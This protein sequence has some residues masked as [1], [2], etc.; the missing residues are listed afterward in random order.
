[1]TVY[2]YLGYGVTNENGVAKLK[3][4]SEGQEIS[5]SYTGVGAGEIDVVASLD[6]PVSQGSIVSETYEVLDCYR[7]DEGLQAEGHHNDIWTGLTNTD[8][9][10]ETE[11]TTIKEKTVGT[12]AY[13]TFI[14]IPLTDYHIEVDVFQVDGTQNEGVFT[15]VNEDYSF[16][17][18]IGGSLGEWKHISKDYHDLA[19]NTRVRIMTAGTCTETRFKNFKL[20]PI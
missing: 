5:H 4:N 6:N 18:W 3:Y 12:T 8:L 9:T 14:N 1:M 17:D 19:P 11:Y 7:Y 13:C 16:A 15:I 10:R 2:K 20:Y